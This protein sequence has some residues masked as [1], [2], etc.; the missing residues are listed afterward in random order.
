MDVPGD[1]ALIVIDVQKGFDDPGWGPRNNPDME[2][3]VTRLIVAWREAGRPIVFVRH[4]SVVE[5]SPLRPGVAGNEFKDVV[6]GEPDLLISKSVN[7]AFYGEPDLRAWLAERDIGSV[8]VCGIQTNHCAETTAR[9]AGN[10]GFDTY[11]VLDATHTFDRQ[12]LDGG[13]I[14]AD[15]LARV[16]AANLNEEFATVVETS[17]LIEG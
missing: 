16:T 10:L 4:D 15:E 11:F 14:S 17:D 13:V 9:M 8:V 1:A 7:S 12:S 5:D 2:D 3:N 6:S